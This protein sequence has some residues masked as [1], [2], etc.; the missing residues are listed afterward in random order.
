M[1]KTIN[2]EGELMMILLINNIRWLIN[3]KISLFLIIETSNY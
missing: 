1:I 2:N 3:K